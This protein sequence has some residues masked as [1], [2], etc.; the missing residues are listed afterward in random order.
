MK[1]YIPNNIEIFEVSA[2]EFLNAEPGTWQAEMLAEKVGENFDGGEDDLKE[3]R[4][5]EAEDL[6][7]FY[8]WACSPG[9]LPDSEA[10]GPFETEL[11]AIED[12]GGGEYEDE[13][14][15]I[16]MELG[17]DPAEITEEKYDYYGLKILSHGRAEYA[18]GTDEE[19][20]EACKQYV[21]DSAWAFN[22]SFVLSK[23]GLPSELEE[24]IQA[25]Q[26]K[27][28]EG[29]NEAIVA[30]IEKTCGMKSFVES[31]I[32]A[33]G[34]GHFLAS[35]DGDEMELEGNLYAFRIN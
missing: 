25:F 31:A 5:E 20:D 17:E 33:D 34:R 10:T 12:A 6:A 15:A 26:G 21:E 35:Y 7:G 28:C 13:I 18:I 8:W 22:A 19:A 32:S 30:L 1:T 27:E 24:A 9:C 23:C 11:E 4:E 29:A 16:A 14:F 3:I 2:A